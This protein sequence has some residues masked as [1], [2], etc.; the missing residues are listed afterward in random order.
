MNDTIKTIMERRSTRRFKPEQLSDEQIAAII[1]CGLAAPSAMNTQGW[2]FTVIQNTH[3]IDWMND[4]IKTVLP[5]AG[6]QR[7]LSLYDGD[8]NF[9]VFYGAPTVVIVSGTEGDSYTDVN[10]GI[11]TENMCLAAHSLDIASC[12]IGLAKLLFST[13]KADEYIKELKIPSGFR[14][15]HAVCF[16]T[17]AIQAPKVLRIDGKVNYIK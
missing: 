14:P 13:E 11:A 1:K 17:A 9:S 4:Q 3:L 6:R 2:H 16:G 10:C 15:L 7:M 12:I 8:E 5:E